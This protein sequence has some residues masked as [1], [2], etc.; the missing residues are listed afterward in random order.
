VIGQTCRTNDSSHY[1][2]VTAILADHVGLHVTDA[3]S[4]SL[5]SGPILSLFFLHNNLF[6]LPMFLVNKNS[7]I[8]C[9]SS[10]ITTIPPNDCRPQSRTDPKLFEILFY[11]Y[12]SQLLTTHGAYSHSS[13]TAYASRVRHDGVVCQSQLIRHGQVSILYRTM[14]LPKS[15]DRLRE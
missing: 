14:R 4:T 5:V 2:N 7:Y 8:D 6:K 3:A 11:V 12:R 9:T 10:S 1:S 15:I 13:F